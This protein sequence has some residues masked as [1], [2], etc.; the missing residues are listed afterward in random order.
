MHNI[1]PFW[2]IGLLAF[3]CAA[4]FIEQSYFLYVKMSTMKML[5]RKRKVSFFVLFNIKLFFTHLKAF[6][7][8]ACKRYRANA[9]VGR[10]RT[11]AKHRGR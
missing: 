6:F 11:K 1:Q 9:N 5:M 4:F 8:S 7:F 2:S 3:L 10:C